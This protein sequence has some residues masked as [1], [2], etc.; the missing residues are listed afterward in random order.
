M[1]RLALAELSAAEREDWAATVREQ[2]LQYVREDGSLV[3]PARTWVAAAG[4]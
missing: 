3:L 4:A 1:L 2:A